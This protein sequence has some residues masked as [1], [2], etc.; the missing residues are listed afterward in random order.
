MKAVRL[1]I[2][3]VISISMIGV[4]IFTVANMSHK[5]PDSPSAPVADSTEKDDSTQTNASD[6]PLITE[7]SAPL[8]EGDE[9]ITEEPAEETVEAVKIVLG[10]IA[11]E[12]MDTL[13]ADA[14]TWGPGV[15]FNDKNQPN[16]CV[17]L[18]EKY[19]DL[20]AVFLHDDDRIY[21]T[22][23]LGYESGFTN[24]ILDALAKNNVKATFFL[25]GS[26]AKNQEEIVKRIISEGHTVGN[27]SNTHPDM[28]TIT[29]EEAAAEITAVSDVIKEKYGYE[30]Y[31]FRF[32]AGTFSEKTL[33]IA[34]K[35]GHHS[36]FWSFAYNDW[37]NAN[38]PDKTEALQKLTDRLHPGAVYLL[39]PMETNSLILTDFIK[40]A[41][42]A[43]Y[44]I[45]IM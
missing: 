45:G 6:L 7:D 21:L 14:V 34:A 33:A 22:F 26:Y 8:E 10:D 18:Q 39:H 31:L 20:G 30:S 43:G 42:D 29:A 44:E 4:G 13:S 15:N 24:D 28:T 11:H 16:A 5:K 38:Q 37:D 32:P 19:G 35:N 9:D 40:A 12:D 25:T 36:V 17:N 3:A 23:D 2:I 41:K 1:V 27:H